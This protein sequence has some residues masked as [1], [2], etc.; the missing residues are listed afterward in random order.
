LKADRD[1]FVDFKT[2]LLYADL[3]RSRRCET[4]QLGNASGEA[5]ATASPV[6]GSTSGRPD[7][8]NKPAARTAWE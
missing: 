8:N 3:V 6:K 5:A 2:K 7:T 4:I 1:F